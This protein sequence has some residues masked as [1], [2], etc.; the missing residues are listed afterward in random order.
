M[1][2]LSDRYVNMINRASFAHL[3]DEGTITSDLELGDE[4]VT[5]SSATFC[6]SRINPIILPDS[7][8][9]F[10]TIR[11]LLNY[12]DSTIK[13][14]KIIT[15]DGKTL[16]YIDAKM[17]FNYDCAVSD[18]DYIQ[19]KCLIQ[20]YPNGKFI[21]L[22]RNQTGI[23]SESENIINSN[24][25]NEKQIVLPISD[26]VFKDMNGVYTDEYLNEAIDTYSGENMFYSTKNDGI[27]FDIYKKTLENK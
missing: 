11:N 4:A 1:I 17:V 3:M 6:D 25:N 27:D 26:T 21:L 9:E 15:F 22:S 20:L 8:S 24:F 19:C 5:M 2:Y 13:C 16:Y 14:K 12:T 10:K 23:G 18:G 7:L